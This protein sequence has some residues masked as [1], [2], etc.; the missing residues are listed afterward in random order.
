MSPKSPSVRQR[1][2]RGASARVLTDRAGLVLTATGHGV[3]SDV[4][5]QLIAAIADFDDAELWLTL[6]VL[7]ADLPSTSDVHRVRRTRELDGP[8][9]ALAAVFDGAAI[10]DASRTPVVVDARTHLVDTTGLLPSEVAH[11]GRAVARQLVREWSASDAVLPVRWSEDRTNLRSLTTEEHDAFGLGAPQWEHPR[12]VVP[13]N[14]HYTLAGIVDLPRA[15]E[16]LVV[17]GQW[18]RNQ[19]ASLGFGL[20]DVVGPHAY[21]RQEGGESRSVWQLAVQRSLGS[22]VV[23]GADQESRYRGWKGMLP[24]IGLVGP[25]LLV[26]DIASQLPDPAHTTLSED[27]WRTLALTIGSLIGID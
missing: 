26:A 17:L 1:A 18:S 15:A 14:A 20:D 4:R 22:L 21:A 12:F 7:R 24:A 8:E 2:F 6:A 5:A 3:G 10:S 9:A 11:T 13:H 25:R 23:M 27:A 19:T 16:R